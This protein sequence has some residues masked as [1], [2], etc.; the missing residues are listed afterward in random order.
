MT[1]DTTLVIITDK[2]VSDL[3]MILIMTVNMDLYMTMIIIMTMIM[4]MIMT[5]IMTMIVTMIVIMTMIGFDIDFYSSTF[6]TLLDVCSCFKLVLVFDYFDMNTV[7][8]M[9]MSIPSP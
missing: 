3:D 9:D 6:H 4:I 1:I 7:T 8:K 5:M 2:I